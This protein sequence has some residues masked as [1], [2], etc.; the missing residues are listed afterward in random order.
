MKT[1]K[2]LWSLF[3]TMLLNNYHSVDAAQPPAVVE[4][5][6]VAPVTKALVPSIEDQEVALVGKDAFAEAI[7]LLEPYMKNNTGTAVMQETYVRAI[8]KTGTYDLAI[9]E[10]QRMWPK[11]EKMPVAMEKMIA[12]SY[13]RLGKSTQALTSFRRLAEKRPQDTEVTAN[14][15]YTLIYSGQTLQGLG[16]YDQL[17]SSNPDMTNI[18]V[19]DAVALLSQ[20][21]ILG[22]RSLFENIVSLYPEKVV[23]RQ[24][25]AEALT[26]YHIERPAQQQYKQVAQ[27]QNISETDER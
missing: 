11:Q 8:F 3:S 15:A 2:I 16:I 10:A 14:L 6:A 9:E 17:L 25:Y 20:G 12:E 19:E 5:V 18:F 27:V 13:L 22:G 4:G 21:N 24:R 23:Y 26:M 1:N 7:I